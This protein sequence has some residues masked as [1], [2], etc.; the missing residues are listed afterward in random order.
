MTVLEAVKSGELIEPGQLVTRLQ[1]ILKEKREAGSTQPIP[2]IR[3]DDEGNV[4][5]SKGGSILVPETGPADLTIPELDAAKT[6]ASARGME[7]REEYKDRMVPYFASDERVDGHG[8]IVRQSWDMGEFEKNSP[9]PYSHEWWAPPVGRAIDWRVVQR[10]EPDYSGPALWLLGLFA[11]KDDW[12][13]ADTV[14]RLVKSGFLPSGSVGFYSNKVIDVKDEDE[15]TELGLGRWGLVFEDNHLLEF[16]PTTIPANEGAH[17]IARAL[18]SVGKDLLLPQDVT[19]LREIVRRDVGDDKEKWFEGEQAILHIA[20]SI[21]PDEE[22]VAHRELDVPLTL[23]PPRVRTRTHAHAVTRE[24]PKEVT[25]PLE[26]RLTLI[27]GAV[28]HIAKRLDEFTTEATQ[29][30]ADLRELLETVPSKGSG[31]VEEV[32]S[33][34]EGLVDE[35]VSS[36]ETVLENLKSLR[37]SE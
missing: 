21:W 20:R 5:F 7:W 9:L 3:Q 28:N 2:T 10:S 33:A 8:D 16:S 35:T 22:F 36:L 34:T 24:E 12:E 37:P 26:K 17:S 31:E 27:E 19:M 18:S 14:F 11:T 23:E 1:D 29:V 13:W 25:E 6:L 4:I 15:R 30:F 32:E